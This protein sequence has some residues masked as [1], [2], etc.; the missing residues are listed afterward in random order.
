MQ[1]SD[2]QKQIWKEFKL[3]C[4]TTFY[5]MVGVVFGLIYFVYGLWS[6]LLDWFLLD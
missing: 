5:M 4:S 6:G 1:A 2:K 3:I